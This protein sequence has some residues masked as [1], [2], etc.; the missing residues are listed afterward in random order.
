MEP[1]WHGIWAGTGPTPARNRADERAEEGA[2]LTEPISSLSC[3][4]VQRAD[5]PCN[6]RDFRAA[7]RS[8]I[9]R[10]QGIGGAAAAR[11]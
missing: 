4:Q 7:N 11:I 2:A 5:T 6:R 10:E 8:K 9:V 1:S 3:S